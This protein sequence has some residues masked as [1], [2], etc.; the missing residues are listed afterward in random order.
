MFRSSVKVEKTVERYAAFTAV[1][2]PMQKIDDA[3][4][5]VNAR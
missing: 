1:Y 4:Y 5:A 3:R 2:M